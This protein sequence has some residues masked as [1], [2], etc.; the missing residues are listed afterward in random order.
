M[1]C[2][3]F[4]ID[5]L[6]YSIDSHQFFCSYCF[7]SYTEDDAH[8]SEKAKEQFKRWI[9]QLS[10][11]KK[12]TI[13]ICSFESKGQHK[14]QKAT[15]QMFW[16]GSETVHHVPYPHLN[17]P[18]PP[19]CTLVNRKK[20]WVQRTNDLRLDHHKHPSITKASIRATVTSYR[21]NTISL[22]GQSTT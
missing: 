12:H 17:C 19:C 21:C 20:Q 2:K 14:R 5:V 10:K 7:D 3:R 6:Q 18:T 9:L 4:H 8:S 16:V 15:W 1:C 11:G 13:S 22:K